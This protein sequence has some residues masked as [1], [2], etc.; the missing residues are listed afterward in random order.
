MKR[1]GKPYG[2]R[3]DKMTKKQRRARRRE[4]YQEQIKDEKFRA[5]LRERQ[6]I[7][8]E[9]KRREQGIEPR[10][11]AEKTLPGYGDLLPYEPLKEWIEAKLGNGYMGSVPDLAMRCGVDESQINRV[12]R[13]EHERIS[14]DF[15][16]KILIAEGSTYL[17]AVYPDL[18]L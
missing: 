10:N 16:D 7:Y 11:F 2:A 14:E 3:R 8:A 13:G 17:G 6:R 9:A 5:E 4:L 12:L 18:Y 15:V 1:R